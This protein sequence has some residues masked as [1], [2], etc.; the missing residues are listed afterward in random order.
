MKHFLKIGRNVVK[1][2]KML[3]GRNGDGHHIGG[4][5]G[6]GGGP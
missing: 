2:L 5:G 1:M 4:K 6:N 3:F